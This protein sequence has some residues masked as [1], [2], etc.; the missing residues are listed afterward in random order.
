MN[1]YSQQECR[2]K[3]EEKDNH[4]HEI[5]EVIGRVETRDKRLVVIGDLNHLVGD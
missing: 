5:L 1:I 3:R 2:M 4:W